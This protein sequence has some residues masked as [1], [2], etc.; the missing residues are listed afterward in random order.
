MPS[1]RL[2][3][4]YKHPPA[5]D[6]L[7]AWNVIITNGGLTEYA[8]GAIVQVLRSP[9]VQISPQIKRSL[10]LHISD[11]M[12]KLL[13][14]KVSS[15]YPNR[16]VD[17]IT[18]VRG[19]LLTAIFNP[20]SKDGAALVENF[21]ARV[22]FR[23]IDALRKETKRRDIILP[24]ITTEDGEERIAGATPQV[25]PELG[26]TEI[27]HLLARI[28]DARKRQAFWLHMQGYPVGKSAELLKIDPTTYRL[29]I[30]QVQEFL[31]SLIAKEATL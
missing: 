22:H 19:K 11:V 27:G 28:V 31:K 4:L 24:I 13:R 6:D 26:S 29:W 2:Q 8:P 12:T 7:T 5:P 18:D 16:G 20:D 9:G 21:E 1:K 23:C 30:K 10:A 17:I 15:A 3:Q 25:L 14:R